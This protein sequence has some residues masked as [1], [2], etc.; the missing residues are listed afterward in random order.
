MLAAIASSGSKQVENI[1]IKINLTY[2]DS[3]KFSMACNFFFKNSIIPRLAYE[4]KLLFLFKI[5]L[6]FTFFIKWIVLISFFSEYLKHLFFC[7]YFS[8]YSKF[9]F[10]WQIVQ[11]SSVYDYF[12]KDFNCVSVSDKLYY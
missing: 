11:K 3:S 5:K 4:I 2:I 1:M 10:F 6:F 9:Y 12:L 7:I 8:I